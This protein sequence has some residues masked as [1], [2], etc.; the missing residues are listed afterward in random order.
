VNTIV[1][2]LDD[3]VDE[4]VVVKAATEEAIDLTV[5]KK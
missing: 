1:V 2:L 4:K 5:P 3:A